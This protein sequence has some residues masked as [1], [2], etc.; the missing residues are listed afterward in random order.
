MRE[1]LSVARTGM[2][3]LSRWLARVAVAWVLSWTALSTAQ[4][5][6]VT[7]GGGNSV[8]SYQTSP[9]ASQGAFITPASLAMLNPR[10][11][12]IGPDGNL[13]VVGTDLADPNTGHVH[14]FNGQ[15]GAFIEGVANSGAGI[16]D[17]TWGPDTRLYV[18]SAT[19]NRVFVFD[20]ASLLAAGAE[21][22][23]L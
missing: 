16:Y 18:T 15:T 3:R 10:G 13:Y 2:G 6:L 12:T 20:S 19:S 23:W 5:L 4:S 1:G 9:P 7:N 21:T 14:R 17:L 11:M 8:L 22:E